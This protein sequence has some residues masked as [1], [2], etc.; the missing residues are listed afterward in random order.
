MKCPVCKTNTFNNK[1]LESGLLALECSSCG[2][3]WIKSFQYWKWR[4]KHGKNLPEKPS[5]E[6]LELTTKDT[7]GGKFCPECSKLLFRYK[8]GHD[9]DFSLDRCN[10]CGGTWFDKNEWEILKNRNLHDDIHFIFSAPWQTKVKKEEALRDK[11]KFLEK[12]IGETDYTKV[13]GIQEWLQKHAAKNEIWAYL[14][15]NIS[16]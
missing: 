14:K 15:D 10:V 11:E 9:L 2:G 13:K 6:G 16:W 1:E 3:Y 8:V 7:K 12:K 4:D 5:E